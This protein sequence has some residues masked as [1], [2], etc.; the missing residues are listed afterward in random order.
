MKL[1]NII[2]IVILTLLLIQCNNKDNIVISNPFDTEIS[3]KSITIDR[4]DIEK[5]VGEKIKSNEKIIIENSK[6]DTIPSQCDDIDG[7]GIWDEL[8]F[9]IDIE[10]NEKFKISFKITDTLL[11][12]KPETRTNIRFA[13]KHPP[14]SSATNELR[15][16][17]SESS[18]ISDIYQMEGP[19][20]ENDYVGFRN[21]YDARNGIDIF[22]KRTKK[23]ALHNAGIN[24][25]DYHSLD[26]WGMDVLKVNNSLGAGAIAIGFND[27]IYRVGQSDKAGFKIITQGPLRSIIEL[28][29]KGVEAGERKY[30]IN[31]QITIQAGERFYR[32]KVIVDNL[33]GDEKLYTGIVDLHNLP[34]IEIEYNGYKISATHGKQGTLKEILSMGLLI[35][36]QYFNGYK[37]APKE[38]DGITYTHLV[39]LNF[40]NNNSTEYSFF[41]GWIYEN[42]N[43]K[44]IEY[45]KEEL[46]NATY[47]LLN[48]YN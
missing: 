22:G 11:M 25:Q 6:G 3:D 20:L 9:L 36:E 30:D 19:A 41:S 1:N 23:M 27:T 8:F 17:T 39:E 45:F 40:D 32:S 7:D 44:N 15:L 42:E 28:W 21:Y 33:I 18:Q 26:D 47:K 12:P 16:K 35:S 46:K 10:S 31:Q 48:I 14:H 38:G 5:I 37:T 24:G 2:T 34:Q 13:H 43:F 4:T 29:H